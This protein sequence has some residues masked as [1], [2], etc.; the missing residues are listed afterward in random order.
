MLS[1]VITN[2][3]E[4]FRPRWCQLATSSLITT[5]SCSIGPIFFF[6]YPP[7]L[8]C[9]GSS[10]CPSLGFRPGDATAVISSA[11]PAR[12]RVNVE[13]RMRWED[14]KLDVSGR[15]GFIR[16]RAAGRQLV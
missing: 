4:G 10:M 5:A 14:M 1:V 9:T 13:R 7:A 12:L 3:E 2:G 11:P 8:E 15:R 16:R 6:F